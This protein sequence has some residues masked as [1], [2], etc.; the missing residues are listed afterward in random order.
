[1][2]RVC[3]PLAAILAL[4]VPNAAAAYIGPGLGAGVI[5]VVLGIFGAIVLALV[6]VLYF[7]IKR[8]L[9]R[10]RGGTSADV[11]APAAQDRSE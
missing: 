2:V 6:A 8:M 5:G 4:T 7:P 9:K 11:S 3:F 10:R 1:M